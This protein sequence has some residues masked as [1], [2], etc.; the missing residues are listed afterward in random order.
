MTTRSSLFT[1]LLV[2][3]TALATVPLSGPALAQDAQAE[4]KAFTDAHHKMMSAMESMKP[5][6]DADKDFVMMMI[7]HH[8]G[9]IDMAQVELQYGKDPML[10]EMAGQIIKA[11]QEEIAKM[12][13]WQKEHGM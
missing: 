1:L 5:T 8:Q 7:P 12:Q 2:A 11:Q 10:R 13:Q 6:G 4:M 3:S 9:A